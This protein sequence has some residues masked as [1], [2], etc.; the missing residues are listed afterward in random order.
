MTPCSLIEVHRRFGETHGLLFQV[1]TVS[2]DNK[3]RHGHEVVYVLNS[4]RGYEYVELYLHSPFVFMVWCLIKHT[5]KFT[6]FVFNFNKEFLSKIRQYRRKHK[7]LVSL[8][9][10]LPQLFC[11]I[12]RRAIPPEIIGIPCTSIGSTSLPVRGIQTHH[13]G[14]RVESLKL[15]WCWQNVGVTVVMTLILMNM[16]QNEFVICMI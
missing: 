9:R 3:A 16:P 12:K 8:R 5:H 6:F 14:Q 11:R 1:R 2:E 4:C 15:L 7:K 10:I 13:G